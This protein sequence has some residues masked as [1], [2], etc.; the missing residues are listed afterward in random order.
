MTAPFWS[1]DAADLAA[2]ISRRDISCRDA[3]D[4]V[5]GRI[6]AVNP[7]INALPYVLAA[8]ARA[9]AAVADRAVARGAL[10][11]PLHGVPVTT[12]VNV[13]Q[14][15]C[16]TTDGL[17]AMRDNIA[18]ED[19]P[20]VASLKA[21][22]A[23]VVGRSNTPAFSL[24][25]FTDNDLHGRTLNPWHEGIT[26]GGSSGGAAAAVASGMGAI[27]HGND[28][29]GSVRHPAYACGVVGLRPTVGRIAAFNPSGRHER[30]ITNQLMSVQGPLTRG[31]ADARL[32]LHVLS[33]PDARDPVWVPAPLEPALPLAPIR[34][35]LFR[36][37]SGHDVDPAVGA[38]VDQAGHWLTGA[39]FAV[40]QAEPP[41]FD[42][43]TDLWRSLV[44]NDLR[45][46]GVPA[47][48]QFGD[49][50]VRT[51]IGFVMAGTKHL[52]NDAFLD[53]LAR[54]LT[55]LRAWSL[56]FETYPVLL[57][58]VS[59]QRPFPI[60]ED[61]H[62]APRMEAVIRAQAPLLSTA[63]LGL[64]GLSVPTGTVDGVPIGVQLC[65]ARFREDLCLLAG[66]AI[67]RAAGRFTPPLPSTA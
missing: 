17:V 19:S 39:G 45:R 4:S 54:R 50:A 29:G 46:T 24:R 3:V 36:G 66:E 64:P 8:E 58:P 40:G 37:G 44:Y 51:N 1:W 7:R 55:I 27:A 10:L 47:I 16:A 30:G 21:A 63:G 26:P 52:D 60:D 32:A 33:R 20:P 2:A 53:G 49:A 31:V 35:A 42:E 11:G 15:G 14:A 56:F 6:E 48:R 59:F 23:I 62:N 25:W 9:A 13:D 5:L 12:K 43:A 41:H 61:T 38:A 22:G 57:M 34:V 67:E 28:Y 65:A 18:T